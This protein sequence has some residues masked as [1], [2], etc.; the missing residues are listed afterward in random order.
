MAEGE[1]TV[2]AT[3]EFQKRYRELPKAIQKK[4]SK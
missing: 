1:V 4:I 2:V 3:E